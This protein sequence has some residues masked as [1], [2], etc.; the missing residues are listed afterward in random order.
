MGFH[1]PRVVRRRS[2]RRMAHLPLFGVFSLRG[3]FTCTS[4]VLIPGKGFVNEPLTAARQTLLLRF[5]SCR[6]FREVQ[7]WDD[8]VLFSD[9]GWLVQR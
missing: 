8:A 4:K 3:T 7:P 2:I 1:P 9:T 5:G 6:Y